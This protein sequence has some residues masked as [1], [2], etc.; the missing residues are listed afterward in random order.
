MRRR[1]H[2]PCR[3]AA[4]AGEPFHGVLHKRADHLGPYPAG[5]RCHHVRGA[6]ATGRRGVI[7]QAQRHGQENSL[8]VVFEQGEREQ[9][10]QRCERRERRLP[11]FFE[12]E[13]AVGDQLL[14]QRRH[15]L[16]AERVR[17]DE[18]DDDA[19]GGFPHAAALRQHYLFRELV[20]EVVYLWHDDARVDND[21]DE[22]GS[23]GEGIGVP[24]CEGRS[25]PWTQFQ[26]DQPTAHDAPGRPRFERRRRLP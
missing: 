25:T 4:T 16:L 8:R 20:H 1:G 22:L 21:A 18:R 13:G 2:V 7:D 5:Q 9:L 17:G 19:G 6:L 10:D 11:A 12:S 24:G 3:P 23:G 14:H 15:T 26:A